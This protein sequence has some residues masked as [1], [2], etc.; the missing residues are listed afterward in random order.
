MSPL[1]RTV[2]LQLAHQSGVRQH[3]EVHVPGLAHS[4]TQLTLTH[5]QVLL[6][7]PVVGLRAGPASLIDLQDAG[8]PNAFDL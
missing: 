2:V 4:V 3:D 5:A 8:L 7:V 1:E 6:P